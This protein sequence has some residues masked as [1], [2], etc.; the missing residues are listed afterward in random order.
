MVTEEVQTVIHIPH[1]ILEL[2]KTR[3]YEDDGLSSRSG[4]LWSNLI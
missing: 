4:W 1:A 2:L 3:E